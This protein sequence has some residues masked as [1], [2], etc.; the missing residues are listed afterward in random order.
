MHTMPAGLAPL[1]HGASAAA[2]YVPSG[3]QPT[4][5]KTAAAQA[6]S[7]KK[8][9][10]EEKSGVPV[11]EDDWD[12]GVE[13][14]IRSLT[15][16]QTGRVSIC[17]KA[18]AGDE[19]PKMIK[20]DIL[21][22]PTLDAMAKEQRME[23]VATQIEAVK[24]H[25]VEIEGNEYNKLTVIAIIGVGVLEKMISS[26]GDSFLNCA[27]TIGAGIFFHQLG[28]RKSSAI[29]TATTRKNEIFEAIRKH[30]DQEAENFM[31]N[32]VQATP[33]KG[34][35]FDKADLPLLGSFTASKA[36]YKKES[37]KYKLVA[38]QLGKRIA[39]L[40][41]EL[42]D[43]D[44]TS[45]QVETALKSLKIALAIVQRP[46]DSK[47]QTLNTLELQYAALRRNKLQDILEELRVRKLA[48][49]GVSA[50]ER[51]SF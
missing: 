20:Y 10:S 1:V 11:V 49:G 6:A 2:A 25:N 5:N 47:V 21:P 34:I 42:R 43:V 30:F 17:G 31:F 50:D 39:V 19:T 45:S 48:N 41:K 13:M 16:L 44:F 33:L 14:R 35:K 36:Y 38:Q 12:L 4:N 46:E 27:F 51:D 26:Y 28:E 32:Y 7:P 23:F 29:Q 22:T 3:G 40:E 9:A 18:K 24:R 15:D 8:D 37:A